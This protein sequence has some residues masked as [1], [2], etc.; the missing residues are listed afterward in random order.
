MIKISK[1]IKDEYTNGKIQN[2]FDDIDEVLSKR[3]EIND[4]YL[5]G[6]TSTSTSERKWCA[7]IF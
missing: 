1:N 6:I 7:N 5:R 4:R 2:L 3:S